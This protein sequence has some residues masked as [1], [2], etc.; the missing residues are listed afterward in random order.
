MSVREATHAGSWYSSSKSELDKQLTS[1]LDKAKQQL[2]GALDVPVKGCKAIIAPHAGY[3]YSGPAAAHAYACVDTSVMQ[4]LTLRSFISSRVFVLGPSHHVPLRGCALTQ[5]TEYETPLGDLVIDAKAVAT[6]KATKQFTVMDIDADE[7]EHSIEMHLPYIYKIFQERKDVRIVPILVGSLTQEQE[8]SYGQVLA[9]FLADPSTL[10]IISSDFCHWGSR[11]S[12]QY[13]LPPNVTLASV[14]D[15]GQITKSIGYSLQKTAPPDA[16]RKI[17]QS[18]Q[19]LDQLGM[20]AVR[21]GDVRLQ[22]YDSLVSNDFVTSLTSTT[23]SVLDSKTKTAGQAHEQFCG[24]LKATRNTICGRHPIGVLLA[25]IDALEKTDSTKAGLPG[26][27][28]SK[29]S[30]VWTR[31]EQS[32]RCIDLGDSSVSYASAYVHVDQD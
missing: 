14:S 10:F 11:F 6:L 27:K 4:A 22:Q 20:K 5:C 7:D 2:P 8:Q 16:Q 3:A 28:S 31:Y 17:W 24:Y 18:I 1:W 26:W 13:Y 19:V 30:L 29:V 32:S 25:T 23:T 15:P 21:F 9:P 12:Y